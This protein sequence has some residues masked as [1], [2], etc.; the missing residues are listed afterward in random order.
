MILGNFQVAIISGA[1]NNWLV[2]GTK[3][4]SNV[5][6]EVDGPATPRPKIFTKTMEKNNHELNED[7]LLLLKIR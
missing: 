5:G 3:F 2:P 6:L 4:C 7:V 1:Q